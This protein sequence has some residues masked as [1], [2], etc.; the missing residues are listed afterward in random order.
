MYFARDA[1][2][3]LQLP[4]WEEVVASKEIGYNAGGAEEVSRA[5]PLTLGGVLPGLPPA[6]VTAS[7]RA[8][9]IA[10]SRAGAWLADPG[11]VLLPKA[12]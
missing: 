7:V 4:Q 10:D 6:G 5:L 12:E 8:I 3:P 9:D 1:G 11:L 2:R